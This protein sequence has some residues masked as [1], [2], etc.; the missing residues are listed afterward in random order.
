[1]KKSFATPSL[2]TQLKNS[3]KTFYDRIILL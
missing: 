2:W 1:L 3:A